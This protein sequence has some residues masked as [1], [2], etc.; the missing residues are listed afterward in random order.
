MSALAWWL[1]PLGA[2]LIALA[3]VGWRN[4]TRPPA[5]AHHAMADMARFREAME[6]P[7]PMGTTLPG[8]GD[9]DPDSAGTSSPTAGVESASDIRDPAGPGEDRR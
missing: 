1:I 3:W 7:N 9:H 6:R 5:D 4:R 8:P 2:T